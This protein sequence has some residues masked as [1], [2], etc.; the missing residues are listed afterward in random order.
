MT[1]TILA[2]A[3]LLLLAAGCCG[4][5][6]NWS[7]PPQPP[8]TRTVQV[9]GVLVDEETFAK[10]A[11]EE[12][13]LH[14]GG[15]DA[16][17]E[18]MRYEMDPEPLVVED[19]DGDG[20]FDVGDDY[21]LFSVVDDGGMKLNEA[22][23]LWHKKRSTTIYFDGA[24]SAA[25]LEFTGLSVHFIDNCGIFVMTGTGRITF[26]QTVINIIGGKII[27]Q[28]LDEDGEVVST[29]LVTSYWP[30]EGSNDVET[31]SVEE[32]HEAPEVPAEREAEADEA[33]AAEGE[34]HALTSPVDDSL[35]SQDNMRCSKEWD[36]ELLRLVI[37]R[38]ILLAALRDY[39]PK[40]I[41]GVH[42][43]TVRPDG[44]WWEGVG[45]YAGGCP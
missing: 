24:E 12:F 26:G 22:A 39:K 25:D 10:I 7:D 2:S 9:Y 8:G 30:C 4:W 16:L 13:T 1:K 32:S 17:G 18:F 44:T 35:D 3:V 33:E 5:P 43:L 14:S 28:A 29:T 6:C 36:Y 40:V 41:R 31:E 23:Q 34:N 21:V 37:T 11:G 15:R 45:F 42:D 27:L 19:A 38:R 20:E